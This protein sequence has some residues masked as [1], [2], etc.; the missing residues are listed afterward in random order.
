MSPSVTPVVSTEARA[1]QPCN[2]LA[3]A[4]RRRAVAFLLL[5]EAEQLT[6]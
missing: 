1:N 5:A 2:R 3:D 4:A 6:A